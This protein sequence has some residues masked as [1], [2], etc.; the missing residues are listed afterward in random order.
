[1]APIRSLLLLVT[2]LLAACGGGGAG[3][4]APAPPPSEL[5]TFA[6]RVRSAGAQ[7]EF[8]YATSS[9]TLIARARSQLL[10]PVAARSQ[11]PIGPIAAGSGGVNLN[12]NWHFT[13]LAFTDAAIALC[14]GTPTLVE[15]DLPYWLNTVKSFCPWG[16]YVDAEVTGIYPLKRLAVGESREIA[17]EAMRIDVVDVSDSRCP[18]AAICVTAGFVTVGLNVRLGSGSPQRLTVTLD[19]GG[20]DQQTVFSGYR[21]TLDRL[22]PYPVTGPVPSEQYRA[23]ITVRKL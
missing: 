5:V 23:D 3:D 6:F 9:P 15:A 22:D 16:G 1:M 21:F 10:L 19:A 7:Q 20:R 13:D 8:R 18:A 4:P 2:C 12:W 17:Q 14:D 11:F